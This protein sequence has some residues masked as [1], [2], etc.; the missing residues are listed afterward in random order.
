[1]G[2]DAVF[3]LDGTLIDSAPLFATILNGMLAERGARKRVTARDVAPYVTAGGLAMIRSVIGLSTEEAHSALADFRSRLAIARTPESS[4]FPGARE[5]LGA[6]REA[7]FRLSLFSNKPQHLCEKALSDL[8]IIDC[9]SAVVGTGPGVPMKPD[10]RGLDLALA[11]PDGAR[12]RSC[13]VGDSEADVQ[14]ART[15]GIP[16]VLVSWGYGT[17]ATDGAAAL[18]DDFAAVPSCVER[19]LAVGDAP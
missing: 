18:A 4:L 7:G 16:L 13:Y 3:D 11:R 14:L 2:R 9:F 1:M 19:V 12:H 8:E 5:A 17:G 10:P 15:A 6:L